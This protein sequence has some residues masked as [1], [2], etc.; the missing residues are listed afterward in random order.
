MR[1]LRATSPAYA[2][3]IGWRRGIWGAASSVLGACTAALTLAL[4]LATSGFAASPCPNEQLRHESNINPKAGQPYSTQLPDCRAYEMVTPVEKNGQDLGG[5]VNETG[6]YVPPSFTTASANG[7]Q[8]MYEPTT[9]IPGSSASGTT[10]ELAKRTVTGWE[11]TSLVPEESK[12]SF[13][14]P[15]P[16]FFAAGGAE[17]LSTG[18]QIT[19]VS[20]DPSDRH[21]SGEEL[22]LR[23]PDGSFEWISQGTLNP[24]AAPAPIFS[25]GNNGQIVSFA[26]SSDLSHVAFTFPYP[27]TQEALSMQSGRTGLYD[28]SNGETRLVDVEGSGSLINS[29]G[30]SLGSTGVGGAAPNAV[31]QNGSRIFFEDTTNI[32]E[33][34]SINGEEVVPELYVR[35]ND[36][37]T[38]EASAPQPGV[39]DSHGPQ[40]ALFVGATPDGDR[41]FF[42]SRQRLTADANTGPKDSS[43]N[44]YEYDLT[45]HELK[46]LTVTSDPN[47]AQVDEG[48]IVGSSDDGAIVYF[49]AHGQFDGEGEEGEPNLYVADEGVVQY[50]ATLDL[51]SARTD[52]F[53]SYLTRTSRVTPDGEH[54]LFQT[55]DNL[56]GYDSRG[57]SELYLFDKISGMLTCVS[58]DQ[59]G[60]APVGDAFLFGYQ[61]ATG[62][63]IELP[64]TD[65]FPAPA[66]LSANGEEVIFNSPDQLSTQATNGVTNVYEYHDGNVSL[67]SGGGDKYPSYFVGA[68]PDASDIYFVTGDSL[69]PGDSDKGQSDIYDARVDGGFE[70]PSPPPTQCMSSE[71]CQEIVSAPSFGAPQTTSVASEQSAS[72]SQP[73]ATPKSAKSRP[74]TVAQRLARALKVCKKDKRRRK[75]AECESTARKHYGREQRMDAKKPTRKIKK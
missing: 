44:L 64:S 71:T 24:G 67:I 73:V 17:D 75:R 56:T 23:K 7:Q 3:A 4:V 5:A 37:T 1:S 54:L 68:T 30:A 9:P 27:L 18:L 39:V 14:D 12:F 42:T 34:C 29:C 53:S 43:A 61:M 33:P 74:P 38:L 31:S 69:V 28:R 16:N 50:I 70:A 6:G 72:A 19:Q 15:Y 47:G 26:E 2:Q 51:Q 41:A 57:F 21:T 45:T 66:N 35:E 20:L 52:D 58:C 55:R 11:S 10:L 60:T 36:Q 25:S 65:G 32:D 8:V 62:E 46:D 13:P 63:H 49:I 22:Y 48:A 40:P 59:K